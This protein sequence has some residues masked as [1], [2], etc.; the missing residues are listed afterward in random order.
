MEFLRFRFREVGGFMRRWQIALA[1]VAGT[2]LIE[3]FAADRLSAQTNDSEFGS[4]VSGIGSVEQGLTHVERRVYDTRDDVKVAMASGASGSGVTGSTQSDQQAYDQLMQRVDGLD[5]EVRELT[6]QVEQLG[7]RLD[8][9]QSKFDQYS[10]KPPAGSDGSA[11][12]PPQAPAPGSAG[13]DG[14]VPISGNSAQGP[15]PAPGPTTLGQVP[16]NSVPN[17]GTVQ[18]QYNAA[19]GYLRQQDY[20]NAEGALKNFLAQHPDDQLAGSATYW[21]GE[22][23]YVENDFADA[24]QAFIDSLKKYPTSPKAADSMLKLGMS[25]AKLN[26]KSQA[27][28]S[29]KELPKKYPSASATIMQRAKVESARAGCP[30][31]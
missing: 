20:K 18:D 9:L 13:A 8:Q 27:C 14:G 4:L 16:A 3:P 5:Q 11:G 25:L 1:V 12:S 26:Q 24:A 6:D 30:A 21:L 7:N 31:G 28:A 22:T 23:Y 29:F 17:P 15:G 2:F 10:G 19:L